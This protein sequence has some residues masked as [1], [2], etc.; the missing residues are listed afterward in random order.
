MTYLGR[1]TAGASVFYG[2]VFH[3]DQGTVENPA[4][5]TAR[6]KTPAGVWSDLATPAIQDGAVGFYGGTI[7]TTGYA[8]G[9]YI[10][11]MRGVVAT[12]KTVACVFSFEVGPGPAGT[13]TSAYDAAKTAATATDLA[14]VDT[15]VDGIAA[16]TVNLPASPAAVGSEMILTSAYDAAKT[17]AQAG[18]AMALTSAERNAVADALGVRT[19]PAETYAADGAVPTWAQMQYMI[20]AALAQFGVAGLTIS[21]KK[22]D[23]TTEAMTFTLDDA[24]KPTS[25]VRAT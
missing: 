5:P 2:A 11:Q 15:V 20:W 7:D 24:V 17:A 8:A 4:T 25:R 10:I 23:G 16:K 19:L 22:L 12:A 9:Q 13:L 18:N 1:F 3:N 21:A 14:T 6:Q